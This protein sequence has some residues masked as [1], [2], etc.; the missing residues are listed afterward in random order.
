MIADQDEEHI[1]W[2]MTLG[3]N[4]DEHLKPGMYFVGSV[5]NWEGDDND[6]MSGQ[7]SKG[8]HKGSVIPLEKR[9]LAPSK[10][11]LLAHQG[12]VRFERAGPGDGSDEEGDAASKFT[13]T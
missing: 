8:S 2:C 1:A 5:S 12:G 10:P 6:S 7:K 4:G 9:S 13:T 3:I 11:S